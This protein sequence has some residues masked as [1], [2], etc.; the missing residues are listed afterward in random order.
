MSATATAT[1]VTTWT[2]DPVHSTAEFRVRH[3]MIANVRGRFTGVSGKLNYNSADIAKSEIESSVE[4][5]TID[6]RDPQR[7]THLK[8]PD[9][10]DAEKFPT[11]TF[12]S[13]RVTRQSNGSHCR[14]RASDSFTASRKKSNSKS[15]AR[16]R[17]SKIPGATP[18]SE[19]TRP[20]RSTA[21]S[22]AS[23]LTQLLRPAASSSAKRSTS[24]SNWSSSR[25]PD[26]RLRLAHVPAGI[27]CER[28]IVRSGQPRWRFPQC[29][30]SACSYKSV[31]SSR[32][33]AFGRMSITSPAATA[34]A[35]F[36]LN[37]PRGVFIEVEGEPATVEA[38]VAALPAEAP[39]LV[40]IA[41]I[42]RTEIS[43][44]G[45]TSFSIH[46]SDA[47]GS[48]FALVPPDICVCDACL[49]DTRSTPPIA[50]TTI[51]SPT[52]PT[53]AHATASSSTFLTTAP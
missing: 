26:P 47:A 49:A 27:V 17:L 23:T 53:A 51:P 16:P 39:P 34:L 33:S 7:D 5:A 15:K 8:S 52:A 36:V 35:G 40:R 18:A 43:V 11:M 9:F 32:A 21:A 29:K 1:A 24:P 50:A 6:T 41:Q 14:L 12:H 37:S 19:S 45:E 42:L 28:M 10:F 22:S 46:E 30:Q 44:T 38:F 25:P 48:A 3:M 20:Q 13:T 2:I 31:A 4:V